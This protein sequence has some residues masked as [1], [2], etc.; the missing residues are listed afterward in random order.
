MLLAAGVA[1]SFSR[2]AWL[3]VACAAAVMLAVAS[4]RSRRWLV[5]LGAALLLVSVLGALGL[6]PAAIAERINVVAE[7]F[8]PFDVR[9]W[10]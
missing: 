3:G 6:L 10:T 9:R 2:G 8:G 5:P 4:A 7:Y 1:L